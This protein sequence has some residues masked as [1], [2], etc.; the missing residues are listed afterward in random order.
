MVS[1][2]LKA[3]QT[4]TITTGK[5]LNLKKLNKAKALSDVA[6][7]KGSVNFG[8]ACDL[9]VK[10]EV[11]PNLKVVVDGRYNLDFAPTKFTVTNA[12]GKS[13][14]YDEFTRRGLSVGAG[15]EYKF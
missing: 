11:I 12:K 2:P 4:G 5:D 13:G 7:V 15:V 9:N 6:E 10:Y 1:F 3:D 8:L 14:T